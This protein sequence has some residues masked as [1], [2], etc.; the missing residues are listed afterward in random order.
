M[1]VELRDEAQDDLVNGA[2]FY[3][4]QSPGLDEYFLKCLQEDI[5]K[6]EA[7]GGVHEQYAGFHRSLSE[8]FPFAIYYL[9]ANQVI[10]VVAILACRSNP[11]ALNLRLGL[12]QR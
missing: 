8:R 6:L 4:E 1:N 5:K 12:T 11:S 7:T 3:G 2:A 10:D 9:V